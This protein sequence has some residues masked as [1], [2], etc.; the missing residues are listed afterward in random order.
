MKK[1]FFVLSL[2]LFVAS[3]VAMN[4]GSGNVANTNMLAKYG[5]AFEGLAGIPNSELRNQILANAK[6]AGLTRTELQAQ[7]DGM[8]EYLSEMVD[9]GLTV[10][11]ISTVDRVWQASE[12]AGTIINELP[13]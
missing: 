4:T 11:D 6:T 8:N 10:G 12:E 3:A 9:K 7:I 13:E 2:S 5:S 1:I